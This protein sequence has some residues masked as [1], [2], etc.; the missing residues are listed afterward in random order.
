MIEGHHPTLVEGAE[1]G[2]IGLIEGQGVF[3]Q[4]HIPIGRVGAGS[5]TR[6]IAK[7]TDLFL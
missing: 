2:H 4:Y 7:E 6:A 1:I 3:G 5:H